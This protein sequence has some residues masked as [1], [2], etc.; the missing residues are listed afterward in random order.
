MKN[1][2]KILLISLLFAGYFKSYSQDSLNS[3]Y[4]EKKSYELYSEQNW[5]ELIP[6]VE[7]AFDKNIDYYYLRMRIGIALYEKKRY[8]R[9]IAHFEK[10]LEF[11][12]DDN[13]SKEYIYY[14][15]KFSG[16]I[17]EA[18]QYAKTF[19]ESLKTKL[20]TSKN[21]FIKN[22]YAETGYS[23][24]NDYKDLQTEIPGEKNSNTQRN[25]TNDS[26]FG[27]FS[28]THRLGEKTQI[29]HSYSGLKLNWNQQYKFDNA[30]TQQFL[31]NTTQNQYF[32]GI[33]I[34][35]SKRTTYMFGAHFLW[36]QNNYNTL[37]FET[38]AIPY[39]KIFYNIEN[40]TAERLYFIGFKSDYKYWSLG[41]SFSF[42]NLNSYQQKQP[43]MDLTFFP[44]GNLNFYS[45]THVSKVFES[46]KSYKVKSDPILQQ[47]IGFKTWKVWTEL[48]ATFG[49]IYDYVEN[50]GYTIYNDVDRLNRRYGINLI[51][52]INKLSISLRYSYQIKEADIYKYSY[53][54][55][56][57]NSTYN[58]HNQNILIGLKL[59]F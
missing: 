31:H 26:Y 39:S 52:P 43:N 16:K 19:S 46:S 50:N 28:L 42:S 5:K 12:P 25:I 4:F 24:N 14:S 56:Y 32:L 34:H 15:Y 36:I 29:V 58:Y 2:I 37:E 8:T 21:P 47:T 59:N 17:F 7:Q 9:A 30:E 48:H 55:T 11:N 6:I 53:N 40:K 51:I 3:A 45:T 54:D 57:S 23:L 41:M 1:T 27:N 49:T 22:I 13:L 20:N 33:N 44:F 10:A 35:N 38:T 18:Q